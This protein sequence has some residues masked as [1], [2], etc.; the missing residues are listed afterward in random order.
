M[1]ILIKKVTYQGGFL[2]AESEKAVLALLKEKCIKLLPKNVEDKHVTINFFD[3]K[4]IKAAGKDPVQVRREQLFSNEDLG[5]VV[6]I[7]VVAFGEYVEDGVV[8]NQGL[9]V[10]I[11]S[12]RAIILSDG[13]NLADMFDLN[14]PHVTLA[15]SDAVNE[16]GKAIA[17][18]VNTYKCDFV[19]PFE[20]ELQVSLEVCKFNVRGTKI[21][22]D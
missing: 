8:L 9:E 11:E 5:K 14:K 22:D 4:A 21:V 7:K 16:N 6:T 13:R 12:L 17:K 1:S 20:M 15:L 3:D 18:A 2:T 10:D 19:V